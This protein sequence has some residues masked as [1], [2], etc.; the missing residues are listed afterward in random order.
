MQ[1]INNILPVPLVLNTTEP[2][3][4]KGKSAILHIDFTRYQNWLKST[5]I[6]KDFT[7]RYENPK[8]VSK[9]VTDIFSKTFPFAQ[10]EIKRIMANTQSHCHPIDGTHKQMAIEVIKNIHG[11][12]LGEDI[13][14]W[15]LA[16]AGSTR[17]IGPILSNENTYTFFPMFID[18][19][20]LLYPSD[21]GSN[22]SK[23]Y[24]KFKIIIHK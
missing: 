7:N 15:Q 16:A 24:K 22:N 8:H 20:H 3:D 13:E 6:K 18:C 11:V 1:V 2:N 19:N 9:T 17:V 21:V 5:S 12:E 23:D 14:I 10:S 4:S